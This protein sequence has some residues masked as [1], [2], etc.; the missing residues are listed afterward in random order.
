LVLSLCVLTQLAKAESREFTYQPAPARNPLKGLVPYAGQG[1]KPDGS[2]VFPHS[3][4]FNYLPLSDVVI[5][6]KKYDWQPLEKLLNDIASRE[7]QTVFRFWMEYPGHEEGIPQYLIDD[8]LKVTE[9]LNT[10]T[11]PF[12]K[13][14]CRTPDYEDTRM[15]ACLKDFIAA[16]GKK[17]DNDPRIGYITAGLLG[18][19]GEWHE[20]PRDDLMASKM[21]QIEVLKAFDAAFDHTPVLL[22]YPAGKDNYHY[23]SNVEYAL[24]YHDDSFAWATLD[25]GQEDDDWFFEPATK[26]AGATNKWKQQPIGGEIRPELW[27]KIF[28]KKVGNKQ[29]QDFADCVQHTHATWLMDTGMFTKKSNEFRRENAEKQVQRMGYE[30]FITKGDFSLADNRRSLDIALQIENK[31]VAPFYYNWPVVLSLINKA[32]ETV[33]TQQAEWNLLKVL[34]G[35]PQSWKV[36]LHSDKPLPAGKHT[37]LLRVINPMKNGIPFRFANSTQDSDKDGWLTLWSTP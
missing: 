37:L 22:R 26:A 21:V 30:L 15:R 7:H 14:K 5:G 35:E 28:D 12:P 32:G 9:W 23:A 31:G 6:E 3:L 24:G 19:W 8:G 16:L 11:A 18:T 27:G 33:N 29:A 1:M 25:T 36:T 10:N 17:Y 2:E 20:Y 4:E 13:E 34:P